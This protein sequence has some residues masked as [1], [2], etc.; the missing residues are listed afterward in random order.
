MN[1]IVPMLFIAVS[2]MTFASC[3]ST[4]LQPNQGGAPAP[5]SPSPSSS[6]ITAAG[7]VNKLKAD[8][9]PVGKIVVLAAETDSNQLLGRPHQYTGKVVWEDTRYSDTS[10]P[11][12][13][14]WGG[15][16]EVFATDADLMARADYIKKLATSPLF[17]E[18]DY[19]SNSGQFLFRLA[20]ELTPDQAAGYAD[21]LKALYPDLQGP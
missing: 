1:R 7:L 19:T 20:N 13:G 5:V 21:K 3:G 9:L 17:A 14:K 18:Y 10:D 11:A 12:A 15:S 2:G 6:A 8:G 4:A 16:I